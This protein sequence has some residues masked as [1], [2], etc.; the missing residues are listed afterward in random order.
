[1][2]VQ[3][4]HPSQIYLAQDLKRPVSISTITIDR[5]IV[6][7]AR[8]PGDAEPLH[9]NKASA[10]NNGKGLVGERLAYG[11]SRLEI[12]RRNRRNRHAPTTD[13]VPEAF[14]RLVVIAAVQQQ[15]RFDHDVICRNVI[16]AAFQDQ[17][18]SCIVA[19][20]SNDR[21]KPRRR[22]DEDTQRRPFAV[23]VRRGFRPVFLK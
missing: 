20:A 17:R 1:M 6:V 10:I 5:E 11:P 19:V 23:R 13:T 18:G 14:S 22:V 12:R 16:A 2:R 21:G 8:N 3:L 7:E 9:D 15:P 4:R